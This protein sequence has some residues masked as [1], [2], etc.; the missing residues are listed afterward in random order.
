MKHCAARLKRPITLPR[1][2]ARDFRIRCR[3]TR[4]TGPGPAPTGWKLK[5]RRVA[6]AYQSLRSYK[7]IHITYRVT[8]NVMQNIADI[9]SH[10]VRNHIGK[11]QP[12][13]E[14]VASRIDQ[15]YRRYLARCR[16]WIRLYTD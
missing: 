1:A 7:G 10:I 3:R 14:K 8:P 11:L 4:H 2:S 12:P 13:D 16:D 6:E 5:L 15:D 9:E